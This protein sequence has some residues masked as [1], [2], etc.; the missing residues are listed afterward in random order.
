MMCSW[1]RKI[2]IR[3][4]IYLPKSFS[5]RVLKFQAPVSGSTLS[6]IKIQSGYCLLVTSAFTEL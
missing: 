3:E 6:T 4:L 5:F 2:S 1:V